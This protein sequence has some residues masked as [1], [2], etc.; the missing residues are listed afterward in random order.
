MNEE[1]LRREEVIPIGLNIEEY[2]LHSTGQC[3]APEE[4]NNEN[5]VWKQCLQI[6]QLIIFIKI[7]HYI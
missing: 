7:F 6:I 4:Q 1:Y 5:D 3:N 2:T